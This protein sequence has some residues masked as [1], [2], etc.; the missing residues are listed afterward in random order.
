MSQID[1][2]RS[3][4]LVVGHR[5]EITDEEVLSDA[6][7]FITRTKDFLSME[8]YRRCDIPACNCPYWHGGHAST[9]LREVSD[10]IH[11]EWMWKGTII[12]SLEDM[13]K[14]ANKRPTEMYEDGTAFLNSIEWDENGPT[15]HS[16]PGC[17]QCT[18][19]ATPNIYN[20][21]PCPYHRFDAALKKAR[22]G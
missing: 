4:V 9:R 2:L 22:G 21:G 19:G 13:A 12:S 18:S 15:F 20:T 16:D 17:I 3:L 11:E 1:T 6:I 10:L 8:G 5:Q 14:A 7:D